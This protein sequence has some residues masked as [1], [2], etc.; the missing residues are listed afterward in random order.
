MV[1]S[2]DNTV[3]ILLLIILYVIYSY[4]KKAIENVDIEDYVRLDKKVDLTDR[5]PSTKKTKRVVG[6]S[7]NNDHLVSKYFKKKGDK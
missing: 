4:T 7:L 2:G 6:L 3:I 1:L 5:P